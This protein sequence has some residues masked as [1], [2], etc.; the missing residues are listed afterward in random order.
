MVFGRIT[1]QS[2]PILLTPIISRLYSPEDFGT[3]AVF[4]TIVSIVA[5]VSSLRYPLSII[6]PE[7]KESAIKLVF[8]SSLFTLITSIISLIVFGFWGSDIFSALNS[9]T[10]SDYLPLVIANILFLGL[11]EPL[12]YYMLR[13][14]RYKALSYNFIFQAIVLIS[15]RLF[16]G[17]TGSTKYGLMGSYCLGYTLSYIV[18][19]FQSDILKHLPENLFEIRAYIMKYSNF[20]KYSLLADLM[21]TFA[22]MSPNLIVNKLFSST[23]AGFYS[24]SDKIMDTPIWFVTSSVGD[25]FKQEASEQLRKKGNC[26]EIFE[27]TFKGLFLTG[28]IPFSLIFIFV[29]YI[30]PPLLGSEWG[31]VGNYIRILSVTYFARFMIS[32][33]AYV[34]Y[35]TDKQHY[36]IIFQS[37]KLVSSVGGL[38]IGYYL[39]DIEKG[40][41]FWSLT[42]VISYVIIYSLSHKAAK[43]GLNKTIIKSK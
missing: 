29:P 31:I 12:F 5:L 9:P 1:A 38:L 11:Y 15:L 40:L 16:W 21:A 8:I 28:I 35:I 25:V 42:T 10:L 33:V 43:E 34:I 24:M 27:K 20:F 7:K 26:K 19:L 30:I 18:M 23:Q 17:Y 22:R 6:L 39:G 4:S 2:L 36:G 37:L 13:E 14:K 3:F 32:P 41:M